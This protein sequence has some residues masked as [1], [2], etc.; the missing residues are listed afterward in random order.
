MIRTIPTFEGEPA[1]QAAWDEG[2]E[3]LTFS[4]DQNEPED[5]RLLRRCLRSL[6]KGAH[7]VEYRVVPVLSASSSSA[8]GQSSSPS[9]LV[10][11][12]RRGMQYQGGIPG[13]GDLAE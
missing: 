3:P 8:G 11:V 10:E 5:R 13:R 4:F 2:Y 9:Q 1:Q 6:E 7:P 12:W